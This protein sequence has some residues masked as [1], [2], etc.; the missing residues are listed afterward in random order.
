MNDL[1]VVGFV[2]LLC[3]LI[4]VG[5]LIAIAF[6]YP[7]AK[8]AAGASAIGIVVSFILLTV[9]LD[10]RENQDARERGF[11]S[12][13]PATAPGQP[14]GSARPLAAIRDWS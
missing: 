14:P 4:L 11:V 10:A 6:R 5:S 1:W 3:M 9:A 8:W 12:A 7:K 2:F 13:A